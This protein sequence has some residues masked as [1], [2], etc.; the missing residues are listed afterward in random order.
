MSRFDHH[1]SRFLREHPFPRELRTYKVGPFPDALVYRDGKKLIDF[2]SNDYLGLAKHPFLI[3]R[4]HEFAKRFGAGTSS[5][6]LVR[7]NLAIFE[8][9]ESQLATLLGKETTL[10][11][12]SGFEA[13]ATL[14]EALLDAATL[15]EKPLVFCDKSCHASIYAGL[16]H[17]EKFYR[18][19]HNN[20]AHLEQLLEKHYSPTQPLFIIVESI[21]SMHGDQTDLAA[22]TALAKKYQALL[23]IDDAHGIGIYGR[24]GQGLAARHEDIDLNMGTFSKGLGSFGSYL[25]CSQTLKDYLTHRC[26]GLMYS[27]ALP[28]SVLGAIS[29][30][31]ELLP[32]LESERENVLHYANLIR[33]FFD[34]EQLSYGQSSTHIIP[35]ILGSAE[36][37]RLAA[38][39][40]EEEGILGAAIQAPTVPPH[41]NRIRFCVSAL[42]RENDL[43]LLFSSIQKVKGLLEN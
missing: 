33:Q 26:K 19:H 24:A 28:P 10:I 30:A 6:R 22:L 39:L 27:T 23:Y 34:Q 21:Y 8:Q 37:T 13:N 3:A 31:L 36:K 29:A 1:Y 18:F 20:L 32:Q 41:Q 43:E 40:L 5:S 4:S 11:M 38:Q 17:L 7:G 12:G 35:W 9:L 2:S 16:S 14:L 42:H 15:G 25:A